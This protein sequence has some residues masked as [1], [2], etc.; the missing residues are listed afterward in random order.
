[1]GQPETTTAVSVAVGVGIG[2][3]AVAGLAAGAAIGTGLMAVGAASSRRY[4]KPALTHEDI[5][6]DA[7]DRIANW[8]SVL[9]IV[10]QGGVS[11]ELRATLWP[12]LLGVFPPESTAA[13][14]DIERTRLRNLYTKLVLVCQEL[15]AQLEASK[16]ART[17]SATALPHSTTSRI[18]TTASP[19]K[20]T[21]PGNL[22]AFA[23]AHRII[24]MDAVRTDLRTQPSEM[25]S[26]AGRHTAAAGGGGGGGGGRNS[27]STFTSGSASWLAKKS[28]SH[29][30]YQ[31]QQEKQEQQQQ[32]QYQVPTVTVLPVSVG[33]GLPELMLI[34]PPAPG[35]TEAVASGLVPVW[36]SKL[37]STTIDEATH[38][39]PTVRRLMMRMVN[40]LSAYAMHDPESGYCQ[41]MSDLAATFVQL[42]EDDALAFACFER[43]MR[44]ARQNF[45]HDEAG[46]QA[47]LG[48]VAKILADTDPALFKR[49]ESLEVADCM[50]AYRMVIVMLRRELPLEEALTLWEAKWATEAA[51]DYLDADKGMMGRYGSGSLSSGGVG[52]S[53]QTAPPSL[54]SGSGRHHTIDGSATAAGSGASKASSSIPLGTSVLRD[55]PTAVLSP[56]Q[57]SSSTSPLSALAHNGLAATVTSM[58]LATKA[59]VSGAVDA[60][61]NGEDG[62]ASSLPTRLQNSSGGG[63]M[64]MMMTSSGST[65]RGGNYLRNGGGA[66]GARS[67]PDLLLHFV[68][69]AIRSQRGRIMTECR[70]GDDVL[71]LFNSLRIDFWPALAQARK[72]HKAYAQGLAVLE[73]L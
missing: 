2:V 1:M 55:A 69:A 42:L 16:A 67:P 28:S 6:W 53:S 3:A 54:A 63:M 70:D 5:R 21:L 66:G 30:L 59:A 64:M 37:A 36:R 56:I 17:T 19:E 47:Q 40:I 34:D 24:V 43:L 13:E 25:A 41:G 22:A 4:A 32:Q 50:F 49:L 71:R 73:R 23:E 31:Q 33:D 26:G 57:S 14:R 60:V 8:P 20:P 72:Q 15:E 12:F 7:Q 11:P 62:K 9:K 10:Q 29:R 58:D 68:V 18:A 44:Q 45:R 51:A 48:R 27:S 52:G 46:I 39:S 38:L 35:P 65:Q 61:E